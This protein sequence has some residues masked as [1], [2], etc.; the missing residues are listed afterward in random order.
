MSIRGKSYPIAGQ[1]CMD[2]T[3]ID[4]GPASPVE[5]GDEVTL[6]GPAG[7][8]PITAGEL[9]CLAGTIPYEIVTRLNLNIPRFYT[10]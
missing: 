7:E 4:L 10:E 1:V 8:E 5:E 6:I 2:Y 9:A 3:V